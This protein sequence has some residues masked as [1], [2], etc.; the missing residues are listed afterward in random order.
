DLSSPQNFAATMEQFEQE[1]GLDRIKAFHLNDS[2]KACAS[3]VDRHSH[4]GAGSIGRAGF[5]WL[6]QQKRFLDIPM[7]LETPKGDD[8]DMDRINLALLRQLGEETV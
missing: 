8:G 2:L 4:I 1:V 7:V 3:R 5:A 6:M